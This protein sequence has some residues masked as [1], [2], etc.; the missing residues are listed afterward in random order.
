MKIYSWF[1]IFIA[2][3]SSL[4]ATAPGIAGLFDR[5]DFFEQGQ[6]QFEE[7][8][9][10]LEQQQSIPNASLTVDETAIPW[11]RVLVKEVG[12]TVMMPS[13]AITEEKE[14]IEA[15]K[16]ELNFDIIATHPSS[17]RYVVAYSEE[18]T[19]ERAKNTQE[20]LENIY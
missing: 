17:S 18:V 2:L 5:P 19:P 1:N 16:G 14:T 6:E 4:I 7:E 3:I 12:F 10:R 9:R 15:P 8:I 20:I 13:G 11:S